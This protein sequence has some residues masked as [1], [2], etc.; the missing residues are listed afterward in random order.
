MCALG[1]NFETIDV[2]VARGLLEQA[3]L[4]EKT[5]IPH[6][7]T[8]EIWL[9]R[10]GFPEQIPYADSTQQEFLKEAVD[11]ILRNHP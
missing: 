7:A 4:V 1:K 11:D 3:G 8:Y 10:D 6:G 9:R 5:D 2:H